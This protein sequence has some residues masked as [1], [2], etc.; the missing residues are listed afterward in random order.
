MLRSSYLRVA[1]VVLGCIAAGWYCTAAEQKNSPVADTANAKARLAAARKAYEGVLQ[2]YRVHPSSVAI[3]AGSFRDWSVRWMQAR[4]E[5]S[6]KKDD[7]IAALEEH[8]ERMQ[9][10]K[11]M[12]DAD[13]KNG[14][15]PRVATSVTEFFRLEAEDWLGAAKAEAEKQ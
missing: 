15:A 10:W 13:A 2:Q 6:Q 1:L 8:L 11:E 14:I 3:E 5:L 7:E 4:H 9:L 12:C